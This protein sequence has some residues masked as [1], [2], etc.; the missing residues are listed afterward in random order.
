MSSKAP[1]A[2]MQRPSVGHAV[3]VGGDGGDGSD[4]DQGDR[5]GSGE[6]SGFDRLRKGSK[7]L[8]E[9]SGSSSEG[10][11]EG[12]EDFEEDSI[13]SAESAKKSVHKQLEQEDFSEGSEDSACDA[14]IVKN[15]SDSCTEHFSLSDGEQED[16]SEESDHCWSE[17]SNWAGI[18]S[19]D[20]DGESLQMSMPQVWCAKSV[21]RFLNENIRGNRSCVSS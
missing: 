8:G 14:D 5:S 12:S 17:D 4:S 20:S 1:S 19:S 18:V 16:F 2:Y 9:F 21:K 6:F 7:G 10:F 11:E 3:D 13:L 15:S